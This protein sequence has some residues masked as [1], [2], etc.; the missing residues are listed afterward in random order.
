MGDEDPL[1]DDDNDELAPD[2]LVSDASAVDD[3]VSEVELN[4]RLPSLDTEELK[5]ARM[6]VTKVCMI[7]SKSF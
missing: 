1:V 3:I 6:A 5:V 7:I 4:E 2:V